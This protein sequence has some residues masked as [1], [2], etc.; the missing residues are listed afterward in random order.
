[1][2]DERSKHQPAEGGGAIL[3]RRSLLELAGKAVA[4]AAI[5]AGAAIMRPIP[6]GDSHEQGVS[7]V[8]HTL[9]MYMGDAGGR[10]LPGEVTDKTKQHILD[11]LGAMISGF[12]LTPRRGALRFATAYGRQAA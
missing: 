8:M 4:S 3:S 12:E 10:A 6:G 1:M 11:T 2:K 7:P 5:P 9:S